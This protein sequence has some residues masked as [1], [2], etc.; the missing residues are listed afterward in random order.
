[1]SESNYENLQNRI[2]ETSKSSEL[3]STDIRFED[4]EES[5]PDFVEMNTL[6]N[7]IIDKRRVLFDS[8]KDLLNT[9]LEIYQT[10]LSVYLGAYY[11][12]NI[13]LDLAITRIWLELLNV[14]NSSEFSN[15]I[16]T[17]LTFFTSNPDPLEWG[18]LEEDQFNSF[19]R[20]FLERYN[21]IKELFIENGVYDTIQWYDTNGL[22]GEDEKSNFI[23][24]TKGGESVEFENLERTERNELYMLYTLA[25]LANIKTNSEGFSLSKVEELLNNIISSSNTLVK[26]VFE[27]VNFFLNNVR[28]NLKSFLF[29]EDT[30][31]ELDPEYSRRFSE[32][33][34]S[35]INDYS[36]LLESFSS[37]NEKTIEE[38][39]EDGI[40]DAIFFQSVEI[41]GEL[42]ILKDEILRSIK[43]SDR[44]LNSYLV[45]LEL[46]EDNKDKLSNTVD[47][48]MTELLNLTGE[49]FEFIPVNN[50]Y[51]NYSSVKNWI[52]KATD[53][54]PFKDYYK[55]LLIYIG[56][57]LKDNTN[58]DTKEF[59]NYG[60]LS[61]WE[62]ENIKKTVIYDGNTF[63]QIPNID[64]TIDIIEIRKNE[65]ELAKDYGIKIKY[66]I[67]EDIISANL[68]IILP[69][70]KIIDNLNLSE[71]LTIDWDSSW[72]TQAEEL[73]E[74]IYFLIL[75]SI[76]KNKN[77]LEKIIEGCVLTFTQAKE[78][79]FKNVYIELIIRKVLNKLKEYSENNNLDFST[80]FSNLDL[81]EDET[82]LFDILNKYI[83]VW[84][85][86]YNPE[87]D[88]GVY[89][90]LLRD[91]PDDIV[92]EWTKV[93]DT[94]NPSNITAIGPK[95]TA[96]KQDFLD[97]IVWCESGPDGGIYTSCWK[98]DMPIR[99][100]KRFIEGFE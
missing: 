34:Y 52:E 22:T 19:R 78:Y 39:K 29:S 69:E 27:E 75:K 57:V 66:N 37:I 35:K 74:T 4:L 92:Y 43:A 67:N 41:E 95:P 32:D 47:E 73:N 6:F 83:T 90:L 46:P 80:I 93:A 13:K 5:N 11:H 64:E 2:I 7:N 49:D 14:Y 56:S 85:I 58:V 60:L 30:R 23:E 70:I 81:L 16:N 25:F 40:Y 38:L 97:S 76:L 62:N 55:L 98:V 45:F 96:S 91:I 99:T 24:Y 51:P 65:R 86:F 72:Y 36:I 26:E 53:W 3:I 100:F 68:K 63:E 44:T 48:I 79:N 94:E 9:R 28:N 31:L 77:N 10:L 18:S 1:M 15:T 59:L 33:L 21:L 61:L 84:N 12:E 8:F 17:F 87:Y 82:I 89:E 20:V 88:K 54:V 42:M 71:L 50:G